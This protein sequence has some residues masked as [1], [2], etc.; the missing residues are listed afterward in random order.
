MRAFTLVELL[1]VI[2]IIGILSALAVFGAFHYTRE[3]VKI[4]A[5]SDLRNCIS[6]LV[7]AR[8]SG[9]TRTTEEIVNDCPKSPYTEE[10]TL[11]SENPVVLKAKARSFLGEVE[12]SYRENI[13]TIQCSME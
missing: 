2:A 8:Q 4:Q 9:D 5:L 6:F 7:I 3:A 12:C 1:V 13:G 10:I 11:E